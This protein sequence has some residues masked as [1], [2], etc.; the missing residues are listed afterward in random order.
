MRPPR[1]RAWY[2]ELRLPGAARPGLRHP[3]LDEGGAWPVT[4]RVRVL[5]A[6]AAAIDDRRGRTESQTRGCSSA[7]LGDATVRTAFGVN[8][9]E[10]VEYL[11]RDRLLDLLRWADRLDRLTADPATTDPAARQRIAADAEAAGYRV[12]GAHFADRDGED[13]DRQSRDPA[14][15]SPATSRRPR[16]PPAHSPAQSNRIRRS[17]EVG[18]VPWPMTDSRCVR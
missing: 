17:S 9:W 11:G 18:G 13:E 5:L 3:G 14:A 10:G 15:G 16:P 8:T 4:D 6:L 1:R 2:D 7:W 12:G